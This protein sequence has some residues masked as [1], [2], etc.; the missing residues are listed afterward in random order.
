MPSPQLRTVVLMSFSG[1]VQV[2]VALIV[3]GTCPLLADK[4]SEQLGG[5]LVVAG[6]VIVIEAVANLVASA[7]LVAVTVAVVVTVTLGAA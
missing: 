6:G 1:S 5:R 3:S 7:A 2:A 4:D